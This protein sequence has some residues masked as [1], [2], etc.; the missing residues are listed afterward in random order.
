MSSA[1]IIICALRVKFLFKYQIFARYQNILIDAQTAKNV[2]LKHCYFRH[3]Q[4]YITLLGFCV[5]R[6]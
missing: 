4:G 1:I 5:S 3:Y 6:W 2:N